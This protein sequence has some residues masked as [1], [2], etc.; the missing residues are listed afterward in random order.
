[1][2][3]RADSASSVFESWFE[4]LRTSATISLNRTIA[5]CRPNRATAIEGSV[6][7]CES[8]SEAGDGGSDDVVSLAGVEV[9]EVDTLVEKRVLQRG[10]VF[11]FVFFLEGHEDCGGLN[12]DSNDNCGS[13]NQ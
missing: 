11:V 9:R 3:A 13:S 1:L 2:I 12:T 8:L 7:C 6:D 5:A 10:L 4:G